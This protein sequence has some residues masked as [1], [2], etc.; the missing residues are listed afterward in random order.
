LN[1]SQIEQLRPIVE[2]ETGM[3]F[4]GNRLTRLTEA[5]TKVVARRR[6]TTDVEHLFASPQERT[7]FL[8]DLTTELTIGESFFFRNE[9]HFRAL[10]EVV[11][12]EILTKN[13]QRRAVRIWSA[14][15]AGGEE[16][17]SLAIL[18]DQVLGVQQS[19][20]SVSILAT[21][22]NTEFLQRARLAEY[23]AWSF[24]RTEIHEDPRYFTTRGDRSC[25]LPQV[26]DRAR[27]VYLNLVKDVYPSP[28]T[29][30]IGLDLILFR[31]VAI[32]LQ[33]DVIRAIVARFCQCLHPGGWLLLGEAEV[34]QV[35]P[36]GFDVR[37]IG[38]A[39]FFQ[40]PPFTT[41]GESPTE[42]PRPILPAVYDAV[43]AAPIIEPPAPIPKMPVVI[44]APKPVALPSVRAHAVRPPAPVPDEKV[45]RPPAF[46]WQQVDRCLL[47]EDFDGAERELAAIQNSTQ[48]ADVKLKY[49]R[50]LLELSEMARARRILDVCL[51]EEPLFIDGHLL[52]TCLAEERGELTEAEAACRRALYLDR[53]C[54][55]AHFHL[56]LIQQQTG[57]V[58]GARKSLQLVQNLAK[59]HDANA[60]VVHGDGVCYGRLWEMAQSM[61]GS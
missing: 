42:L 56:A 1:Q 44:T 46:D 36:V 5:V 30:T 31:N 51:E 8:E 2:A 39:T 18:L 59:T 12:P 15:C 11:I 19:D 7:A 45:D 9:H 20:W 49:V 57:D 48:R 6:N 61:M 52:K 25:L 4:S 29:G 33:P 13:S 54:A 55:M 3:D 53:S 34:S 16:P 21:D 26:R 38:Q 35:E 23:R 10:R 40:K 28:L 14:G 37:R 41:A 60:L 58:T 17:Y 32:Y 47:R 27:F 22:I 43:A 50:R 24:R